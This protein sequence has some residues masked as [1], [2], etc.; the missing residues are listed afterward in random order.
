[1]PSHVPD[2]INTGE[3]DLTLVFGPNPFIVP[4]LACTFLTQY[5]AP[6]HPETVDMVIYALRDGSGQPRYP[7]ETRFG[8]QRR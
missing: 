7:E 1:M 3:R 4:L 6:P 8:V 2:C 5:G